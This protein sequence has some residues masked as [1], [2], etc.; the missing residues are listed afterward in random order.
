MSE[1]RKAQFA[2]RTLLLAFAGIAFS[3]VLLLTLTPLAVVH[4]LEHH[5]TSSEIDSIPVIS[6]STILVA[7]AS[8]VLALAFA[9]CLIHFWKK[10][11]LA[12]IREINQLLVKNG[13]LSDIEITSLSNGNLTTT[14]RTLADAFAQSK[15]ARNEAERFR[16]VAE[17]ID[18]SV[19]MTDTDGYL[20]WANPSFSEMTGYS[21]EE[22]IGR[23]PGHFLRA[24]ESEP[25]TTA[26]I[27]RHIRDHKGFDTEVLN[28]TKDGRRF[29]AQLEVRPVFGA[30]GQVINF[31]G[32]ERDITEDK[33]TEAALEANRVELQQRIIDLQSAKSELEAERAKLAS[34]ANEL[35]SAKDAA[36]QANRAKSE[37]LATVS[38][39]LRT[40]MNGVLGMA[41][42]LIDS[43]LNQEQRDHASAIK[44]SGE[45]LLV[46]LN[47]ILDLSRLEAQGLELETVPIRLA[48]IIAAVTD[49][50]RANANDRGLELK[51]DISPNAPEVVMGD[52]TRLR[53]I[54]FNL[55]SNAIK[56][57]DQGSVGVFASLDADKGG[58]FIRID[59]TDTGI[60]I[61]QEAQARLFERFS[62]A[63][64]SISRTHGGTGLGLA[65]CRELARLMDGDISV[66]STPGEGSK[67]SVSVPLARPNEDTVSPATDDVST[68]Q[69]SSAGEVTDS[70]RILVAEDQPINAKLMTAI[71]GRLNHTLTIAPNGV[72]VIKELRKDDFDLILMDIQMPEMDGILAT[73]V[74]RS[75]DEPWHDIPIIALTAHAM[76]GT[77]DTYLQAGMNGFVSKPI[78]IDALVHEIS[79][80][81]SGAA[82]N[83]E[84]IQVRECHEQAPV[85]EKDTPH[86]PP[87][88]DDEAFLADM[89][90]DLV[91]EDDQTAA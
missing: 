91:E 79:T 59:V 44:D 7:A 84:D 37:F 63:D 77:R 45:S 28:M 40:P 20:V 16:L 80:V 66:E 67:F 51:T 25:S 56:F 75:S 55:T 64:S 52:P 14:A 35:S 34:S 19:L 10:S 76:A 18:H 48:D 23:K 78:S 31:I 17:A 12:P 3:A 33:R 58:N 2:P 72:E 29:W 89:L 26:A 86:A 13:D 90:N 38:H 62:Q 47:D 39:E 36:E 57:T 71:M 60:G 82:T 87:S 9:S 42:L 68:T 43:D 1:T 8:F 49:V 74:I 65:I 30:D 5:L 54:L 32:I 24:P 85:Q 73:K 61:S 4:M 21:L 46:L 15:C 6:D 11:L 83:G 70:W 88:D 50:M 53:Q 22:V 81:M 27:D 69:S 41:E